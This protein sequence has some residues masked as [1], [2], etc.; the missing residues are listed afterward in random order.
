MSQFDNMNQPAK[1]GNTIEKCNNPNCVVDQC[2]YKTS[3]WLIFTQTCTTCHQVFESIASRES[4]TANCTPMS[5]CDGREDVVYS[6]D[7]TPIN[8]AGSIET[9]ST[10]EPEEEYGYTC[11]HC[12]ASFATQNQYYTHTSL[13]S[14]EYGMQLWTQHD[15][16]DEYG[17]QEYEY[18]QE[19]E[20]MED[21]RQ[22]AV[23]EAVCRRC[24]RYFHVCK[25]NK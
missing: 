13:C 5:T 3:S 10:T 19:D 14:E 6:Y 24:Q 1:S 18:E 15:Y 11:V 23:M 25:C 16:E 7:E 21:F 22:Y 4:H 2:R 17:L 9:S 20:R 8:V 12:N